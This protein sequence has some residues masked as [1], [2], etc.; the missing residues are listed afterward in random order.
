MFFSRSI[1]VL[2]KLVRRWTQHFT[3]IDQEKHKIEQ[4]CIWDPMTTGFIM[5][6]LIYVISMEFLPLGCRRSSLW[7]VLS[8]KEQGKQLFY[9]LSL[10]SLNL[11][12]CFLDLAR[13]ISQ[14]KGT[15][16]TIL[17]VNI[18]IT[19][20]LTTISQNSQIPGICP[21][22]KVGWRWWLLLE[23]TNAFYVIFEIANFLHYGIRFIIFWCWCCFYPKVHS[24]KH[25]L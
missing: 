15:R 10:S 7:N 18:H 17:M 5:Q 11:T 4:I 9:Y 3:K 22:L 14:F 24:L 23:V 16:L 2:L 13:C 20:T 25:L 6:T 8:N 21:G 19:G 1:W 12:P